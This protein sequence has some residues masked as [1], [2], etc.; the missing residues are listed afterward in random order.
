MCAK[1]LTCT[2]NIGIFLWGSDKRANFQKTLC[3]LVVYKFGFL[4]RHARYML[5]QVKDVS[6]LF[7]RPSLKIYSQCLAICEIAFGLPWQLVNI[8]KPAAE[9]FVSSRTPRWRG[10]ERHIYLIFWKTCTTSS[11]WQIINTNLHIF[12]QYTLCFIEEPTFNYC[13][14][15]PLWPFNLNTDP[16]PN[17]RFTLSALCS[18]PC[19]QHNWLVSIEKPNHWK[20]EKREG[21]VIS[22]V[23]PGEPPKG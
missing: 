9:W 1:G 2:K 16:D 5:G 8:E 12:I 11:D 23:I 3:I 6:C 22:L 10:S 13:L 14:G 18:V 4:S 21:R 7:C 17:D 15:L 19:C 20:V